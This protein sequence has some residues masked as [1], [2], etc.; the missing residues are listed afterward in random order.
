M[1]ENAWMESTLLPALVLLV[2][3]EISVRLLPTIVHQL[4]ARMEVPVSMK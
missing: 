1:A 3:L 4:L 2:F